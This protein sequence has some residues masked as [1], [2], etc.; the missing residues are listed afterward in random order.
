LLVKLHAINDHAATTI[1]MPTAV[2]VGFKTHGDVF[3]ALPS[4]KGFVIT[5]TNTTALINTAK[6]RLFAA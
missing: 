4:D 5:A 2:M 1:R 3:L 6:K